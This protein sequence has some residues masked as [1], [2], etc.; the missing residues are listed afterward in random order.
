M[1]I[2]VDRNT[3]PVAVKFGNEPDD[4]LEVNTVFV[5]AKLSLADTVQI[6]EASYKLEF[7]GDGDG[8]AEKDAAATPYRVPMSP[9]G[10]MIATLRHT[11][12]GWEGPMFE[13]IR[14]R[15][16]IWDEID[17]TECEWWIR[18]VK[19]AID[20]LNTPRSDEPKKKKAADPNAG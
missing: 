5:K 7:A 1:G 15:R 13:G 20:R 19:Q 4:G 17:V 16:S 18:L 11:V 6:E 2:L 10:Q 9:I 14:Y 8:R 12:T 3:P